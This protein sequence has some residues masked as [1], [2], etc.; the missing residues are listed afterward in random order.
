MLR[1]NSQL[2]KQN[3]IVGGF[4]ELFRA[5]VN[6]SGASGRKFEAVKSRLQA[7]LVR[8]KPHSPRFRSAENATVFLP[9][10]IFGGIA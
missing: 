7:R 3:Q 9:R 4:G 8:Q 5:L 2:E 6:G 10:R 1:E